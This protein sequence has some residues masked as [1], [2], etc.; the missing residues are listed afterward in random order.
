MDQFNQY[1]LALFAFL[2]ILLAGGLVI[3]LRWPASRAMPVAFLTAAGLALYI[4]EVPGL[5]VAAASL[6][7][8]V[9]AVSLLYIIFGAILLLNTLRESGGLSVIRQGFTSLSPDRR[10]QVIV[11]AW[12]FG[13]FIEGSAGFGSPAAVAVPLL[14]GLGF[15]PLAAIIAGMLI[16]STPVSFGAV[17]TPILVGVNNGLSNVLPD[18][19][20]RGEFLLEVTDKV[21]L[22][23]AACGTFI[24]LTVVCILTRFFGANRSWAEGLRAWRFALFAAFS[25][26][27]PYVL[28]AWWLG[29]EF[30]SL[31][32][33][34]VGLAIVV[35][36]ARSGFLLP[37]DGTW[38]FPDRTMWPAGWFSQGE[39]PGP[40]PA[41]SM[42][43]ARAWL[44]YLLVVILLV[45]TRLKGI[46]FGGASIGEWLG[47]VSL[48]LTDL[49]SSGIGAKFQPL[50]LPGGIFIIA[51]LA[52]CF[53][54]RMSRPAYGRAVQDS[55]RTTLKASV[56]LVF[57]VPM[58]Q[59]F[60]NSG[61][62]ALPGGMPQALANGVAGL[63][64]DAWPLFSTFVGGFGA[65]VAGSNT[66]SN[67]TFAEF[68][69]LAAG[70]IGADPGWVTALQ[71]VGGAAGNVIC[72]HNVVAASAVVGMVGR[73]GIVIRK[74]FLPFVGYA[75]FAGALGYAVIW[76]DTKG[77]INSGSVI[78]LLMVA[79]AAW[80]IY[81]GRGSRKE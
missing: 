45:L 79:L 62:E 38:D 16:Q 40:E 58:A 8:L 7:G 50:Y 75:L 27:I 41:G 81:F 10:V 26:T 2:P 6:K 66:I 14:V 65:F 22:L 5:Q 13:A 4:W 33:S 74:T 37:R 68:Q 36:A 51:S 54:H 53:L 23:H 28:V 70:K 49:F 25:M 42:G 77:W 64:G 60:I 18:A 61:T 15:P 31:L 9:I 24:P 55:L 80:A 47:G 3:G 48:E 71:A 19:A 32:G 20:V 73:E 67:M 1:L 57:T 34:L 78:A 69:Y 39:V 63:A 35:P 56:A 52:T 29:P 76:K 46:Q 30:P 59:V 72:I 11:I 17:G 44:P 43:F 21:A 12:L